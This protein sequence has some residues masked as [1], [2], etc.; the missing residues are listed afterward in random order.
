[1]DY[2]EWASKNKAKVIKH[3]GNH[4]KC[5]DKSLGWNLLSSEIIKISDNR[6]AVNLLVQEAKGI[7]DDVPSVD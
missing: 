2:D 4:A 5:L 3:T 1:M 7:S 6:P